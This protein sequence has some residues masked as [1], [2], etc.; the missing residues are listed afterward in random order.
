MRGASRH[1]KSTSR[2]RGAGGGVARPPP[3]RGDRSPVSG[4]GAWRLCW[5]YEIAG[6]FDD[7][8]RACKRALELSPD[9]AVASAPS[10]AEVLLLQGN[11]AKA[12][13][14]FDRLSDGALRL[15]GVALAQFSLG[16]M[17][18]SDEALAALVAR[19]GTCAA[20]Q[21]AEV[22]A[23]RGDKDRAFEWL[24]RA[25]AEHD[26]GLMNIKVDPLLRS[27]H[28]DPRFDAPCSGR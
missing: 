16:N 7:A 11:P 4:T 3:G 6:A 27:L 19:W 25:L 14:V 28:G 24:D 22:Y 15:W 1:G 18:A 23:W 2:D 10:S 21:I 13:E 5:A 9:S 20:Y 26:G 8:L 12:L 17:R